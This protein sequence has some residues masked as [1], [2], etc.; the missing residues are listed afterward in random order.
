MDALRIKITALTASFR[1]PTF[2]SGI[3]PSLPAHRFR[4]S[5]ACFRRLKADGLRLLILMSVISTAKKAKQ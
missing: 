1:Y 2:I 4:L 3:Q 5:M